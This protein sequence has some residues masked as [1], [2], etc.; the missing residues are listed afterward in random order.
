MSRFITLCLAAATAIAS[1]SAAQAADIVGTWKLESMA[2][3]NSEGARNEIPWGNAYLIYTAGGRVMTV[4]TTDNRPGLS[5]DASSAPEAERAIAYSTMFAY[6]GRYAITEDH[7][8]HHVDTAWNPNWVG[9]EQER[10]FN[11]TDDTLVLRTLPMDS[12]GAQVFLE[13]IWKREAD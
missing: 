12:D 9:T 1:L 8:V 4:G 11:L 13:L 10:V 5:G 2:I 7:V 3:S 6:T